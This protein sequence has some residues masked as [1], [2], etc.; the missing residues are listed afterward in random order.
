M[1]ILLPILV[2]IIAYLLIFTGLSR[3]E[4]AGDAIRGAIVYST[5]G[6]SLFTIIILEG[7]GA[8]SAITQ[9][10]LGIIWTTALVIL[11]L[12]AW[13]K[14]LLVDSIAKL[15]AWWKN[16]QLNKIEW[17]ILVTIGFFIITLF[18]IAL[19]SP[20][21]NTDSL[22]Y[23][24][25][26]IIHWIQDRNFKFFPV[27]YLAQLF[28]PP[29][30]EML[31]L[32]NFLLVGGDR[33]INLQ[34]WVFMIFSLIV[35]TAI[36]KMIGA[37]RTGQWIAAV[38]LLGLPVGILESTTAQNDYV[39]A[40]W[41]LSLVY[42]VVKNIGKN[43]SFVAITAMGIIAGM[44]MLTKV[45]AYSYIAI[46][47]IWVTISSVKKI[48]IKRSIINSIIIISVMFVI[49]VNQW[50][51][52]LDT[53]NNPFGEVEFV[54]RR[55]PSIKTAADFLI[56][57]M[58]HLALNIGTPFDSLNNAM[59]NAI[60]VFCRKIGGSNCSS[61]EPGEWGFRI[62]GL[63]NHEDSVGN[64]L[65]LVVFFLSMIL[66]VFGFKK[67]SYK[68]MVTTYLL[69]TLSCILL[70]SWLVSWG[71]YWGRL[72]L[73]FFAMAAPFI[74]LVAGNQN[75]RFARTLMFILLLGGLPWLLFNRTRP[76]IS[77]TPNVTLVR[78]IFVE[79]REELLFANYPE[80]EEQIR[81]VTSEALK[82]RCANISLRVDSRDP[83]YYFMSYLE[84][85]KTGIWIESVSDDPILDRYKTPNFNAC[86]L[87]CSICGYDP[88]QNGLIFA[89]KDKA[90]TLYLSPEY[91]VDY[92]N[93]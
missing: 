43:T 22:Q 64:L 69:V 38:F 17:V 35:G 87:I 26:R 24:V 28:N 93:R 4:S 60:I 76:I 47:L 89:Y 23:H 83:E 48:G 67:M 52:N 86:A 54:S 57:P 19:I 34:Q 72:Q 82:T 74:G 16:T 55:T 49:N 88:D 78:S 68:S 75:E 11:I 2:Y 77:D 90:M 65:A 63:S 73:P 20:P 15:S 27:A 44:A 91:Y 50:K 85:W 3:T 21:N 62:I 46:I 6:F 37:G 41:I 30:A 8:I 80:L 61:P 33:L 51:K 36:A 29:G 14:R 25:A 7:L 71:M 58:Q 31:L 32:N 42:L 5:G 12:F 59:G 9:P 84:P 70:F 13:R 66:F 40:F 53:F 45:P 1:L 56:S 39:T 18:L 92:K 10:A 81:N 79:S